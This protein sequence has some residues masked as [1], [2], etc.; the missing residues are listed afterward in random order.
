MTFRQLEAFL[1][2]ARLGTVAAAA[3]ALGISQSGLSRLISEL[4]KNLGFDLFAR[5][6]RGLQLTSQGRAFLREV[7][8]NFRGVET[9][10]SAAKQILRGQKQRIRIACLPTLSIALLPGSL[11]RFHTR[12]P[13]VAVELETASYSEALALLADRQVD[14]AITFEA[15]PTAGLTIQPFAEAAYVFAAHESHPLTDR[16]SVTAEDLRGT[17]LIGV[18]PNR[19]YDA[20]EAEEERDKLEQTSDH[21]LFCHTS[22]TRYACVAAG[23]AATL[24]E[25]FA[26]P[27]FA[28][29]GVV[30]RPFVP[31]LAIRYS[32]ILPED[33]ATV[34]ETMDFRA[35]LTDELVSFAESHR[36]DISIG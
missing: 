3:V 26:S 10:Q 30:V 21:W 24:G 8:R 23:L 7:E 6:G 35:A 2:A 31:R 20:T 33:S 9:L 28:P 17:P 29:L 18:I 14:L 1:L 27:L 12:H 16:K 13:D 11:K 34:P 4:E 5:S 36:L 15:P 19:W 25:P 32:V 22:T